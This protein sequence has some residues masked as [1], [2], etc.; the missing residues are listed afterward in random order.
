MNLTNEIIT[1]SPDAIISE[2]DHLFWSG[3]IDE[4]LRDSIAEIG[5]TTPVLAVETSDGLQLISGQARVRLLAEQKQAV[6][7]RLVEDI[8]T[9][10]LGLLYVADNATRHIDDGM[11]LAALQYFSPL[12]D[13]TEL[14]KAILPRLGVKAKSKDAR[15]LMAWLDLP[16]SWQNLLSIGNVPL[17]AGDMLSRMQGEDRNAV[18]PLFTGCSWSRSNAV[19]MLTW[20][21]EAGKMTS[22]SVADVMESAGLTDIL[23]QGL[24]PK[25]TIARL[26]AAMKAARYPSLTKLQEDFQKAAR[27]LTAGT[28]WRMN[29]PNNFETSGAELVV[30]IKDAAQLQ[31][32]IKELES[33][34]EMS[35]WETIWKLGGQND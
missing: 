15:L 29:Q 11:R 10:A 9:A 34:S 27:E 23:K 33:I 7:V 18:E 26:T 31:R 21:F 4:S 1:A 28:R 30:Q 5:Q 16:P 22:K 2:G 17:A 20:L 12:M 14:K 6:L 25:D 3:N 8:D 19:N 24:S 13:N 32:A 35:P